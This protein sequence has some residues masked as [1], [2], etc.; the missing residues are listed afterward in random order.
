MS[1]YRSNVLLFPANPLSDANHLTNTHGE[2]NITCAICEILAKREREHTLN[3]HSTEKV[4]LGFVNALT[5]LLLCGLVSGMNYSE[6]YKQRTTGSQVAGTDA[7]AGLR[8]S[9]DKARTQ[10]QIDKQNSKQETGK[11]RSINKQLD[12]ARISEP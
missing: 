12:K 5:T 7:S 6:P 3:H 2:Y 9:I 10:I 11:G 4:S 1:D 8:R